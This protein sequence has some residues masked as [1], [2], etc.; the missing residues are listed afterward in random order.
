LTAAFTVNSVLTTVPHI[1]AG[2]R[3]AVGDLATAVF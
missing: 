1:A 2:V 3:H